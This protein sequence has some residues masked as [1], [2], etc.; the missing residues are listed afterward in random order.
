MVFAKLDL[1]KELTTHL[2]TLSLKMWVEGWKAKPLW[3]ESSK[4]IELS[5]II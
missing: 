5:N 2:L 4:I 3:C 1:V